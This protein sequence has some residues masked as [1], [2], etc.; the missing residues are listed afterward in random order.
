MKTGSLYRGTPSPL[1]MLEDG[2]GYRPVVAIIDGVLDPGG[3][4]VLVG[5][6]KSYKSFFA[7]QLAMSIAAGIPFL[8][9]NIT[10]PHRV[11]YVNLEIA[12]YRLEQRIRM[13]RAGMEE[14][15]E[16]GTLRNLVT[17]SPD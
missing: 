1:L 4:A 14:D 8:G 11:L 9:M 2:K 16:V 15:C 5:P 10:R 13:L 17:W 12:E 7:L 3:V 6:A